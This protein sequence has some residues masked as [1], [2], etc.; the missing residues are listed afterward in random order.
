MADIVGELS[1]RDDR[2]ANVI[3]RHPLCT[4]AQRAPETSHFAALVESVISQQLSVKAADTI[5]GRV[6]SL[7]DGEVT[8]ER[9]VVITQAQMREAG[10]SGA[11]FKTIHGLAE[12]A[13]SERVNVER[14]HELDD[15]A[16]ISQQL[17]SLWGVGRWTVDMFMLG[18]LG[19]LDV[20][21]TG[22]VGV[23]RGWEKIYG[24]TQPISAVA[25]QSDG[26]KF[27]PYRSVVAWYCWR[28][29]DA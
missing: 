14:L 1:A 26:D 3:R 15:D 10:V 9:M 19:R 22:D 20:W 7:V 2:L 13:I 25:L 18:Q 21:P 11:K 16:V 27:S 6:R 29:G 23:R 28:E 24:L 17:T 4:L 12:A 8:P 5:F